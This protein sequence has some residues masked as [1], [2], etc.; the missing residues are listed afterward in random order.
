MQ[1]SA[2]S[3]LDIEALSKFVAIN[4]RNVNAEKVLEDGAHISK[5]NPGMARSTAQPNIPPF[6]GGLSSNENYQSYT[7]LRPLFI[8]IVAH[9]IDPAIEA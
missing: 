1:K 5:M 7:R 4:F 6:E 8:S 3:C 2:H 9:K